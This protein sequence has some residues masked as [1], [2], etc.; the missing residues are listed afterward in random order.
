MA[1]ATGTR[2]TQRENILD[3]ISVSIRLLKHSPEF[4]QLS[5]KYSDL[6]LFPWIIA[7]GQEALKDITRLWNDEGHSAETFHSLNITSFKLCLSEKGE[8]PQENSA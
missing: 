5:S 3:K 6:D 4:T 7:R 8:G 1:E 2:Q